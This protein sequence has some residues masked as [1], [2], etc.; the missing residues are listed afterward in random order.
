MLYHDISTYRDLRNMLGSMTDAE[1]DQKVQI[2]PP[3]RDGD[4]PIRLQPAICI[5]TIE[6]LCHTNGEIDQETR[7]AD[8][9]KHHPE[10]V[11][12]M[13]DW[14]PYSSDGDEWYELEEDG[15]LRGNNSG[16]LVSCEDEDDE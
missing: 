14:S 16:K 13:V 11:V 5:D 1:L 8:D 9:F 7:S 6:N 2:M 10:Q 15:G 3:N 4:K 12:V